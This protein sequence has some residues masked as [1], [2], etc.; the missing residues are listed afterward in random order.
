MSIRALC[1]ALLF[2]AWPVA[3]ELQP[4]QEEEM[5]QVTGQAGLSI[6]ANL[7]FAAS[8]GQN[9]CPGGCGTRLAI[10]PANSAGVIVLDDI[11]GMFS[12]D[13]V[14][15][16]I[17]RLN[18]GFGGDG[19]AFNSSVMRVGLANVRFGDFRFTLG[20][21]NRESGNPDW[22]FQQTNLLT[23]RANGEVRL[24]GNVYVMGLK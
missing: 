7:N 16:D 2:V 5:Q 13:G 18:S 10:R 9:R 11:R 6:G 24:H 19:A 15:V 22:G 17:E 8:S 3:A 20:G 21:S 12:F 14:T 4:L 23:F 1:L